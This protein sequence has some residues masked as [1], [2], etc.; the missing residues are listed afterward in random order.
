MLNQLEE[1]IELKYP[2]GKNNQTLILWEAPVWLSAL[3]FALVTQKHILS[4]FRHILRTQSASVKGSGVPQKVVLCEDCKDLK[5]IE[6]WA[7]P[8]VRDLEGM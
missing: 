1:F 7:G 6:F 3:P 2:P 8:R 5:E 4:N